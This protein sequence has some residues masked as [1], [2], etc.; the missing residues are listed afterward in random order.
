[1]QHDHG[2]LL[3]FQRPQGLVWPGCAINH[4]EARAAALGSDEA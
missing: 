4:F 1:M 2:P 3:Y